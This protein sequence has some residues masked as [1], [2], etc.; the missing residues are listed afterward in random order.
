[1]K[2]GIRVPLT[3]FLT[4]EFRCCVCKQ[5]KHPKPQDRLREDTVNACFKELREGVMPTVCLDCGGIYEFAH[6]RKALRR[7]IRYLANNAYD[8]AMRDELEAMARA[9]GRSA[10]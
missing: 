9:S 3:H 6:D 2:M 7:Y 10:K 8:D 1:M 4:Y 5:T